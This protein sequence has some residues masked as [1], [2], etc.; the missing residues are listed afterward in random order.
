MH[1]LYHFVYLQLRKSLMSPYPKEK[2]TPP[3]ISTPGKQLMRLQINYFSYTFIIQH[4]IP[5]FV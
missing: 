4:L 5:K 3:A 1:L 2:Q